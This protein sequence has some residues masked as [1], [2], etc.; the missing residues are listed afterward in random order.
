MKSGWTIGFDIKLNES[1]R[2]PKFTTVNANLIVE[3]QL[4]LSWNGVEGNWISPSAWGNLRFVN[5]I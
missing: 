5:G 1:D 4:I 3:G 2:Q